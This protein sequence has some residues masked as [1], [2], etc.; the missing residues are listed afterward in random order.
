[1]TGQLD[2]ATDRPEN[3]RIVNGLSGAD[4]GALAVTTTKE[5]YVD[6]D[7]TSGR[8]NTQGKV[9]FGPGYKAEARVWARDVRYKGQG[10]AF[11]LMPNEIP[12]GQNHIMWPQGGEVD[13]MEYVGSI[14]NHNLGTVHYAWFWENNEYQ[15]WNHGHLG[16]YYSFKDRQG[17][18][19]PE[20]ISIDL[21]SNQTFN[22]VVVNWESAFG[23]SYKI[24][25]SN[26]N[27]NWQDIYT[28]T[29]GSGGLVNIDT[30]ASGR[31]VRLYGTE[32]GTDFGYSVFEL[33]IRN[34]AGVNLAANRSVTASSFQG[35]DV[36]ATMAIDGQTRTRWS[37]NGRNPGYGNYP[38]ALN[39]QN[40][41]SYSWHTYGVNWYNNR[42]EFYVDGNVYHIHYLSDGDGFSPA[43]GGDAGSTKLVNGKRTY[44]SEF[45]NHFPEWH[46]FE[47]QMYVILSAG[48]GGQSG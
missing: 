39:D 21:G 44:V 26:D 32:R 35:A 27:E 42:I 43:D 11:W 24:Q 4:G 18:D 40:T 34:A 29:T 48:V 8:I 3:L 33:E 15:D 45:S 5:F 1:G 9:A 2:R 25:V 38:P 30:N 7:Y 12:P 36:A 41:G 13:I 31:Y 37:S 19:D 47:H 20:W 28:T 46:P 16:G 10:F 14:P 6:K 17:P 23:K 22:K